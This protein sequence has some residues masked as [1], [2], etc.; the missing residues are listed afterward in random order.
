MFKGLSIHARSR[1]GLHARCEELLASLTLPR[2][3]TTQRFLDN[4]A[5]GRGR[6]IVVLPL[7]G[8][9]G[10]GAPSGLWIATASTDYVCHEQKTSPLHQQQIILHECA[11]ML[12]GHRTVADPEGTERLL[13]DLGPSLIR[14]ALARSAYDSQQEAEAET[15]AS[16]LLQAGHDEPAPVCVP[17]SETA[18]VERLIRSLGQH[19][20]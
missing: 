4:L 10:V 9:S 6:P 13:P 7:P 14:R 2:P 11:H 16:M 5:H 18:L 12:F 17:T 1:Q 3:F 15:L 20:G 19:S 8:I